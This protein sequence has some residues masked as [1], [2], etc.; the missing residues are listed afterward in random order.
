[1]LEIFLTFWLPYDTDFGF[2]YYRDDTGYEY[3]EPYAGRYFTDEISIYFE[4][5]KMLDYSTDYEYT[6]T[7]TYEY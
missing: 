1:M 6:M 2:T 5:Y 3:I 4:G 7:F